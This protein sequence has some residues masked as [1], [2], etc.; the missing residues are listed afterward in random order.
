MVRKMLL[1]CF[2]CQM[3][4]KALSIFEI[5]ISVVHNIKISPMPRNIPFLVCTRYEFTNPI[6]VSAASGCDDKRSRNHSSIY[7][8][9]PKPLA[10]AKNTARIGTKASSEEYVRL[11]AVAIT[12]FW[13][14]SM[15]KARMK[16]YMVLRKFIVS[17]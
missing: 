17:S 12:R 11:L 8:E 7:T 15:I 9:Y 13:S 6:N 3:S 1:G 2:T 4:L 10:T 16:V 5:S 14:I